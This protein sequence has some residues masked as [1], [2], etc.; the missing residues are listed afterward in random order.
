MVERRAICVDGTVQGVGF[1][2]IVHGLAASLHLRGL[3][4]NQTGN[5]R[6]SEE[7]SPDD[8]QT[9]F[10]LD[11]RPVVRAIL[12]DLNHQPDRPRIARRFHRTI[13]E[14]IGA[15]CGRIREQ[16]GLHL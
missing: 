13:V 7:A 16:S 12:H 9:V 2:P 3:V 4:R 15:V 1:R 10:I 6:V 8:Q 5:L 14:M 11:S